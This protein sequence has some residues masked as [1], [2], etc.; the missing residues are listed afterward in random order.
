MQPENS[1]RDCILQRRGILLRVDADYG[2][3]RWAACEQAARVGGAEALL[4]V[5]GGGKAFELAFHVL[6]DE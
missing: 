3:R 2:P 1:N 6:L 5:H 4:H